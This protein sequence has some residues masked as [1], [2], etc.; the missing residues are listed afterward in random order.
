MPNGLQVHPQLMRSPCQGLQLQPRGGDF[1]VQHAPSRGGWLARLQV[2]LLARASRPVSRQRRFDDAFLLSHPPRDHSDVL[3]VH[4]TLLESHA[5]LPLRSRMAGEQHQAR[6]GLIEPMNHLRF[7]VPVAQRGGQVVQAAFAL[8]GHRQQ[9]CRLV[10]HQQGFVDVKHVQLDHDR[11]HIDCPV[12]LL[13]RTPKRALDERTAQ[14][15]IAHLL[16]TALQE[17]RHENH[18]Y[19]PLVGSRALTT[20]ARFVGAQAPV[21][22]QLR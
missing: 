5:Q 18:A 3:F 15:H 2:H 13:R 10:H 1:S 9:T 17:A 4:L 6:G 19:C 7:W 8:A 21:A 22:A 16:P 11:Q 14:A 20:P 12:D